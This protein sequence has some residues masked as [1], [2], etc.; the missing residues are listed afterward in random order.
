M[1]LKIVDIGLSKMLDKLLTAYGNTMQL[2]LFQNNITPVGS[3]TLATYQEA[4][5][6]G[7]V[8]QAITG[9]LPSTVAASVATSNAT[10][11]SF[12]RSATG[13]AQTIF[14]YFVLDGSGN[15]LFAER[16][17][18]APITLTNQGDTYL[19]TPKFTYLSEF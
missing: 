17:P 13:T 16:D 18:A 19:I 14:G 7:Y 2:C 11:V 3:D 9:W 10:Q 8:R 15:L 6:P 1:S 5:F 12:Q 4:T